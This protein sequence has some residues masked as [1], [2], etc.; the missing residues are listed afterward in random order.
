MFQ[1]ACTQLTR[2]SRAKLLRQALKQTCFSIN[3]RLSSNA[4]VHLDSVFTNSKTSTK[5]DEDIDNDS[6]LKSSV[7]KVDLDFIYKMADFPDWASSPVLVEIMQAKDVEQLLAV[8]EKYPL[9]VSQVI[10]Y[11]IW[12]FVKYIPENFA[13]QARTLVYQLGKLDT[14]VDMGV[15]I[16]DAR[17]QKCI[18]T[19]VSVD[20]TTTENAMNHLLTSYRSLL[21]SGLSVNSDVGVFW[22]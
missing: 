20:V 2:S 12:F 7:N 6:Q 22:I 8:V 5:N 16:L 15:L 4:A 21:L 1:I 3:N 18:D 11:I 14:K 19:I 10:I 13:F 9:D 17:F